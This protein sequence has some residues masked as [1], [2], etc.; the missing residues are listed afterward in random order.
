MKTD[1]IV[2]QIE[3][4]TRDLV[5]VDEQLETGE[6]DDATAERLRNAYLAERTTLEEQL[7]G[8]EAVESS[9]N[10]DVEVAEATAG[11]S[12]GRAI[13]GT[14]IIGIAA[15]VVAVVA[16]FSLQEQTPAGDMTDGVATDVL[17]GGGT[18]GQVATGLSSV[19]AADMEAVVAENPEIVGMRIALAELYVE[20]GNLPKALDHYLIVLDLEPENADALVRV[21]WLTS[22][23]NEPELAEP[24]LVRALVIDPDYPQAYW[25]LANVRIEMGNMKGAI[26]PLE[27]LLTYEIPTEIRTE[28]MAML[29]EARS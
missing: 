17:E 16:V 5:E 22:V 9:D 4:V 21:G 10:E 26:E 3:Q 2:E 28:A 20:E 11:R 13:A 19:T 14:A 24:F 25:H 27:A 7:D 8:V 29:E 23:S 15:V 12:R 6:I 1:R 18:G